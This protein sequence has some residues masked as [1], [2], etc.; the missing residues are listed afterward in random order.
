MSKELENKVHPGFIRG[1]IEIG[2][3]SGSDQH[4][5]VKEAFSYGYEWE[6]ANS[7]GLQSSNKVKFENRLQGH[8]V[9]PKALPT[10]EPNSDNDTD[11]VFDPA[12]F[13]YTL[14]KLF[15]AMCKT[16]ER[17][18][19][20]ENGVHVIIPASPHYVIIYTDRMLCDI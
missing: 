16:S 15:D 13:K 6:D 14:N 1:Y 2:G 10:A 8:N 19:R 12:A 5:E 7:K 9:W 18:S 11:T 20:G 4:Y 3:E 17:L